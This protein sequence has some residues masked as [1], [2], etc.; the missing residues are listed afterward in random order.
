VAATWS[1]RACE[2]LLR[3]ASEAY[4]GR[5]EALLAAL[6]AQG[7][8]ATGRSGLNVWIPVREESAAVAFLAARGWAVRA[9]E[10]YRTRTGPAIRITIATLAAR[11]AVRLA[12]DVAES[13]RAAGRTSAA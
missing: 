3:A 12:R 6:A 8:A 2:A 11:E 9:G 4:T 7:V 5:R 10:R 13:Q 1:D